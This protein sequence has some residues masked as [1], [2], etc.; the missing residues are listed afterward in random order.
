MI[1]PPYNNVTLYQ[2]KS[3]IYIT[4]ILDTGPQNTH[5]PKNIQLSPKMYKNKPLLLARTYYSKSATPVW[6]L[7]LPSGSD[8]VGIETLCKLHTL[9]VIN[10]FH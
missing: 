2:K 5:A 3:I 7:D 4:S 8:D 10:S 1:T 6:F 9:T